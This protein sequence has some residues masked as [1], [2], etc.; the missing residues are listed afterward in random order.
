LPESMPWQTLLLN[1]IG[2]PSPF[3]LFLS[4]WP[5]ETKEFLL[6]DFSTILFPHFYQCWVDFCVQTADFFPLCY[7]LS[8][9]FFCCW[10]WVFCSREENVGL[11]P[12][13]PSLPRIAFDG[14]FDFSHL[15]GPST[16]FPIQLF[17][18]IFELG[19]LSVTLFTR[20]LAV[21]PLPSLYLGSFKGSVAA[22][23]FRASF[24]FEFS[25]FFYSMISGSFSLVCYAVP[26][27]LIQ[28]SDRPPLLPSDSL[29]FD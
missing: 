11:F 25:F 22:P 1:A 6:L 5:G 29:S 26:Q 10:F 23:L 2:S 21:L 19:S 4:A 20:S 13:P 15:T 18:I 9:S 14:R 3:A 24:P 12:L 16:P 7:P 27:N 28:L 8:P 17:L